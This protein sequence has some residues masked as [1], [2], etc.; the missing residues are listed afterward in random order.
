[1]LVRQVPEIDSEDLVYEALL[2]QAII[3][4]ID[5]RAH[6]LTPGF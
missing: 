4:G 1:M 6:A 2:G 5:F 3:A